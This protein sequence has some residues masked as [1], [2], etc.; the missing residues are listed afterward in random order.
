MICTFGKRNKGTYD[1]TSNLMTDYLIEEPFILNT[2]LPKDYQVI[3]PNMYVMMFEPLFNNSKCVLI[4]R[5]LKLM[6]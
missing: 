6:F 4:S 1:P 2:C 5:L 3:K